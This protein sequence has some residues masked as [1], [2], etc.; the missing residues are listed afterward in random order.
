MEI[1][2]EMRRA[3]H[4]D[5]CARSGHQI[6]T[7]GLFQ[8]GALDADRM[9]LGSPDE[10]KLPHITCARCGRFWIVLPANGRNYDDAERA[11]YGVMRGDSSLGR[12]IIRNRALRKA[13]DRPLLG[14]VQGPSREG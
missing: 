12:E 5:D 1:T 3:V 6:E 8:P 14:P 2:D 11:V 7:G 9:R 4:E 10:L 13:R